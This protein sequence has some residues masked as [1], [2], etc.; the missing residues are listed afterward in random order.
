MH[1]THLQ[2]D[3]ILYLTQLP[4]YDI[5]IHT[6]YNIRYL[7]LAHLDLAHLDLF[8]RD[9]ILIYKRVFL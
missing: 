6:L 7:D 3:Q 1:S 5:I 8:R 2:H 9:A 4:F